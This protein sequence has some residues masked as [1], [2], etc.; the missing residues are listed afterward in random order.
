MLPHWPHDLWCHMRVVGIFLSQPYSVF[1]II[2]W[3]SSEIR[4][5]TISPS[6][7]SCHIRS[8]TSSTRSFCVS[9]ARLS[10]FSSTQEVAIFASLADRL[11]S[12]HSAPWPVNRSF[13]EKILPVFALLF[14]DVDDH[15]VQ[16]LV[17]ALEL[18]QHPG[19][20]PDGVELDRGLEIHFPRGGGGV[21]RGHRDRLAQQLEQIGRAHV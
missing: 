1:T 14:H 16:V 5:T 9:I 8:R 20:L 2:G 17:D 13:I 3:C 6:R 15:V 11:A 21:E 19:H 10:I 12:R 7:S 4:C 18:L